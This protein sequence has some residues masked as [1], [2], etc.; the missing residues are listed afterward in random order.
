MDHY[1]VGRFCESYN[2]HRGIVSDTE[3]AYGKGKLTTEMRNII[4]GYK[5]IT[6]DDMLDNA[7]QLKIALD[8][9]MDDAYEKFS[10][11]I[12]GMSRKTVVDAVATRMSNS[13]FCFCGGRGHGI[14]GN[15]PKITP[16]RASHWMVKPEFYET[17][18]PTAQEVLIMRMN[19]VCVTVSSVPET[20]HWGN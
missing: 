14:G 7:E 18:K 16:F 15:H 4:D 10:L 17:I 19:P 2:K 1:N 13:E 8:K 12:S 5:A 20:A 3:L 6:I 9:A 11:S